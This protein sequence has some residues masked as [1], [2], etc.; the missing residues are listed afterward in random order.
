M[1]LKFKNSI[2]NGSK[3]AY[4]PQQL[5]RIFEENLISLNCGNRKALIFNNHEVTYNDL[6]MAANR[7]AALI[8]DQIHTCKLQANW[9]ND[10]IIAICMPPS[11]D[12]II[13]LLAILKTGA[14]YL[15][16]DAKFPQN[17]IDHILN[18][19]QPTMVIYDSKTIQRN[20]FANTAA[21]SFDECKSLVSKYDCTN[22]TDDR[23]LRSTNSSDLA[24][25]LYTSGSTGI[26]KGKYIHKKIERKT[27]FVCNKEKKI[28][29]QAYVNM[30]PRK[31]N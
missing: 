11:D 28:L 3:R 1:T 10:W 19:A 16:L 30:K 6:N 15:P 24:L 23:T 9:D 8:L 25:V 12:F 20:S 14:A 29:I 21:I 18:E 22:I 26:P 31:F 13:T 27:D 7:M 5:H 17:R 2:I 4:K